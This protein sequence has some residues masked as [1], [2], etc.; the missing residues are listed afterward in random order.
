MSFDY[1]KNDC[2][3][4]NGDRKDC[5]QSQSTGLFHCRSQNDPI[6][7]EQ[8]GV[9]SNGF[10]MYKLSESSRIDHGGEALSLAARDTQYRSLPSTLKSEHRQKLMDRGLTITQIDWL[11]EAGWLKTWTPG[12]ATTLDRK[13]AGIDP[14]FGKTLGCSGIA[15]AALSGNQISGY[16]IAN[17]DRSKAKY[18][19]LSSKTQGG[20]GPHLP[21]GDV[22]LAVWICP[23]AQPSEM[24][25]CEGFLKS[26]ITALR[27]WAQGQTEYM[28]VGAAGGNF[29]ASS[30]LLRDLIRQHQ[31]TSVLLAPDAGGVA[32]TQVMAAY[33]RARSI[34]TGVDFNV[35]WWGQITKDAKDIDEL[36]DRDLKAMEVISWQDLKAFV[37]KEKAEEKAQAE[38][39]EPAA[40]KLDRILERCPLWQTEER[41]AWVDVPIGQHHEPMPLDSPKFKAWLAAEFQAETGRHCG[42]D[43]LGQVLL[44]ATGRALSAP[45]HTVYHRTALVDGKVYLDL[46]REDWAVVEICGAGWRIIYEGCPAKFKRPSSMKAMPLPSQAADWSPL[47]KI[48]NLKDEDWVLMLA[49]LSFALFP[50]NPHP[51]V[52]LNGEQG[53]G[54]SKVSEFLKRLIDPAK[55]LLMSMPREERNLKAHANNRWALV[56][57]NLSGLS[58]EMSDALCRLATGGGLVDRT[59]YSDMDESVFDGVRP[60]ILNGIEA[61]ASRPD[62]LERSILLNLPVIPEDR[63]MTEVECEVVFEESQ[64]AILGALLNGVAQG[65]R[66]KG[67]LKILSLPRMADFATWGHATETAFGFA[68]GTFE[69]A[70][71]SNRGLVHESALDADAIATAILQLLESRNFTGTASQ[72]LHDLNQIVSEEQRR[73]HDWIKS[74][75][76][77]GRRLARLAP[78][79]RKCGIEIRTGVRIN[80]ARLITLELLPKVEKPPAKICEEP[81]EFEFLAEESNEPATLD[82]GSRVIYIGGAHLGEFTVVEIG[83]EGSCTIE[84]KGSSARLISRLDRLELAIAG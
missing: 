5:R 45:I 46:G 77:L 80:G 69:A 65:L 60:I 19:W 56:Y 58:G 44:A 43:A 13:L 61:L 37:P 38:V 55:A 12:I 68:P 11:V 42:K 10:N 30:C 73:A 20:N 51:A 40:K 64:P 78:E 82:P 32:N 39:K 48:L 17:D 50:E 72:L 1:L 71:T 57:D 26:L 23:D 22:P 27:L 75:R 9:D 3:I 25:I 14:K 84:G 41:Q 8:L 62:L 66:Q 81:E 29:G 2:P 47:R 70:Y 67:N 4:C 35:L 6:G 83:A 7:Y 28:V 74:P 53:T 49:W 16:Q 31:I 34:C 52:L 24:I 33:D 76:V 18:L 63:R 21:S 15:I 54:K 59:L 79:L 36:G